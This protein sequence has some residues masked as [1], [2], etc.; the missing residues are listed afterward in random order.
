MDSDGDDVV[1][2]TYGSEGVLRDV[3]PLQVNS[4]EGGVG[5]HLSFQMLLY[6]SIT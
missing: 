2:A 1:V 5:L 3:I 6:V 4:G